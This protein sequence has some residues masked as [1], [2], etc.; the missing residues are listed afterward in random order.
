VGASPSLSSTPAPV[1][2]G[3]W[4]QDFVNHLARSEAERKPNAGLR[5]TLQP[6]VSA[7]A[8]PSLSSL[9]QKR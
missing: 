3:Q 5:I 4:Q 7:S 2:S 6:E 1:S 8:S 9:D